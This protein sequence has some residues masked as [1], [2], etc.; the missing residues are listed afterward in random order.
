MASER[1]QETIRKLRRPTEPAVDLSPRTP[2]DAI[3]AEQIR[4]LERQVDDLKGRLNGLI[5]LVAGAV[6][7]QVVLGLVR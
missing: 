6:I 3:L 4:G 5:L 1:L 2:F 7:V